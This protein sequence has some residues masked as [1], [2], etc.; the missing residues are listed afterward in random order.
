MNLESCIEICASHLAN[1]PVTDSSKLLNG[2]HNTISAQQAFKPT[3][4]S[5]ESTISLRDEPV[6]TKHGC[7]RK[8]FVSRSRGIWFTGGAAWN[9]REHRQFP[10]WPML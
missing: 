7:H 4:M 5:E 10:R 8:I 1:I 6:N 2:S 3:V 9:Q